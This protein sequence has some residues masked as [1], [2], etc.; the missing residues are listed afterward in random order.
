MTQ[1]RLF[2]V[3]LA[4][5]LAA[6]GAEPG[7]DTAPTASVEAPAKAADAMP[8]ASAGEQPLGP[9]ES[10]QGVIE[11]DFGSGMQRFRSL[12][13]KVPDDAGEAAR[14]RLATAE[15]KE[16]LASANEALEGT[17]RKVDA[18]GVQD[19]V[20]S[21]AGMSISD[22]TVLH[23]RSMRQFTVGLNGTAPD[24]AKLE[25]M[26]DFDEAS[27]GFTGNAHLNYKPAGAGSFDKYETSE[28]EVKIKRFERN[29]DGSFTATG[30]FTANNLAGA[31]LS[32]QF[33]GKTLPSASGIFDV[34]A[35][36]LKTL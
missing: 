27:L 36:P 24:G 33:K 14:K 7:S 9:N 18:E 30:R 28:V 21:V 32:D 29:E 35:M 8:K 3:S 31:E 34:A 22:S 5:L 11:A 4:V 17:G 15:G 23:L 16:A 20:D 6:C 19:L 12:A 26:L 25:L 1:L 13:T 2:A 10:L